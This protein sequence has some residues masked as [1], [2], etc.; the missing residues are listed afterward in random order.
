VGTSRHVAYLVECVDHSRSHLDL[1]AGD[2]V[3]LFQNALVCGQRLSRKDLLQ[4]L[5]TSVLHNNTAHRGKRRV[6]GDRDV[7]FSPATQH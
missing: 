3:Q 2:I 5:I 7:C 1:P 4:D 6:S